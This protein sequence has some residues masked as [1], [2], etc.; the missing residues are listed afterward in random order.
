MCTDHCFATVVEILFLHSTFDHQLAHLV[1]QV[2]VLL[3]QTQLL[4]LQ[5]MNL[6]LHS[7]S[8]DT[9][10]HCDT[11]LPS[12]ETGIGCRHTVLTVSGG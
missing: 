3:Q 9:S 10:S 8:P 12:F 5:L 4:Q 1:R 7:Q 2:R 6:I 11:M